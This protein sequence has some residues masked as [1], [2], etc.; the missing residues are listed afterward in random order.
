MYCKHRD[1]ESFLTIIRAVAKPRSLH[2]MSG[3]GAQTDEEVED[4]SP[5][6]K[7]IKTEQ[8]NQ[9][10]V[11]PSIETLERSTE[12]CITDIGNP[13]SCVRA[14]CDSSPSPSTTSTGPLSL[15]LQSPSLHGAAVT[16]PG[17]LSVNGRAV[18]TSDKRIR[19]PSLGV[20]ITSTSLDDLQVP[21]DFAS[22]PSDPEELAIWV[23]EHIKLCVSEEAGF[24]LAE[25]GKR[26]RSQSHAP[27]AKL[28]EQNDKDR[29]LEEMVALEKIRE[30]GRMRKANWRKGRMETSEC[31]LAVPE[32]YQELIKRHRQGQ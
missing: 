23:A 3:P 7:R 17:L 8:Q 16:L 25:A 1:I 14:R 13:I 31:L 6:R 22:A 29:T 28:R 11:I 18:D 10:S 4:A 21:V 27:G 9:E 26:R 5:P 24:E 12:T 2:T 19:Q 30:L 32:S 15:V 20:S